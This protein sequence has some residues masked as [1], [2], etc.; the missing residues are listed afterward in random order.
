MKKDCLAKI[1]VIALAIAL[2]VLAFNFNTETTD[3]T[4]SV[5]GMAE[6]EVVSNEAQIRF[7]IETLAKDSV[8]AE[9]Q[10]SEKSNKVMAEL[11]NLVGKENIETVSYNIYEDREWDYVTQKYTDNGYRATHVI[12][13]TTTD[14]EEVGTIIQS[15][16][17][18]GAT[19][20]N[21]VTF[22]LTKEKEKELRDQALENAVEVA[23]EKADSIANAANVKLGSVVS[24]TENNYYY[25]PYEYANVRMDSME[26]AKGAAA[27]IAPQKLSISSSVNVAY[28]IK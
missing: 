15:G 24:V 13:V 23:Y 8:T 11:E 12:K 26:M 25:S 4:I 2:I 1:S 27:E 19:T 5:S 6:I 7:G 9:E 20:L 14:L 10:N 17:T 22:G 18:A 3:D 28:E 16:I 21:G